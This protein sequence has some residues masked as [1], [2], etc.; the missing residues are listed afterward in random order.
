MKKKVL[1]DYGGQSVL[2][3]AL[4][5]PLILLLALGVFE[6]GRAIH[7]KNM[8][9]NMSREGANLASRTLR[10]PQY[11]MNALDSTSQPLKMSSNGM[12]YITEVS[13]MSDGKIR[14][15]KQY[16]WNNHPVTYP[17]SRVPGVACT[18]WVND[19]CIPSPG[20]PN[21]RPEVDYSVLN[22]NMC[23]LGGAAC[24]DSP[25]VQI[26]YTAEVFYDYQVIF[27][28]IINYS[29]KMYSITVF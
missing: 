29:P 20:D 21:S 5:L 13:G 6:F 25:S 22:L 27:S 15:F 1:A 23:D 8:I 28:S 26:A 12:M 18:P 10:D 3:L 17:P 14:V 9:I 24:P 16:R 7:A 19:V 2:E 4:I 11:I